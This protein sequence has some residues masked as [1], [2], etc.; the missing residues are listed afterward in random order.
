M[1]ASLK[2]WIHSEVAG[3]D[4]TVIHSKPQQQWLPQIKSQCMLARH[5]ELSTLS[6]LGL[7]DHCSLQAPSPPTGTQEVG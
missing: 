6:G 4:K 2:N 1:P 3:L 7:P 5:C